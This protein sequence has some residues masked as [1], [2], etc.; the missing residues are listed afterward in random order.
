MKLFNS[1]V[2]RLVP[3]NLGFTGAETSQI[4]S[5][6]AILFFCEGKTNGTR[7]GGM[8]LLVIVLPKWGDSIVRVALTLVWLDRLRKKILQAGIYILITIGI[9]TVLPSLCQLMSGS[10]AESGEHRN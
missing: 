8:T 10:L 6:E 7:M 3:S 1:S 5:I 2:G 9:D 4:K